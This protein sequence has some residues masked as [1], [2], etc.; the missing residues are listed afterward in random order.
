MRGL[1]R[2]LEPVAL[3]RIAVARWTEAAA[4]VAAA[5]ACLLFAE[6]ALDRHGAFESNAYDFGFF[7]QIIWNTSHGRWFQ[8]SFTPYNFVGQHFQ[9]VLLIFA[10]AY[11]L[12]AGVELLLVTQTV[13]VAAAALPLFYAVRRATASGVAGL[14][15]SAGFLLSASLHDALDFDFHPELMGF[16]FV[17]L[18][19]YYLVARRPVA[20]IVSL[21]PLLLL[22]EDMPLILAAFAVLMFARGFRREALA[23]FGVS[24]AFALG[25][26]LVLMPA[27][28]GG[29]G[30]LTQR[31]GYLFAD[32][33]WWSIVP[34][35]VSRAEHQL[36]GGPLAAV[37]R[38]ADSIGFTGL[39]NPIALLAAAPVFLLATLSDH[40]QQSQLE[41][42]Y[43]MAPLALAWVSAVFGVQRIASGMWPRWMRL[44]RNRSLATAAAGIIVLASSVT[45]F[46]LWSP[47]APGA[48]HHAPNA[49]HRAVVRDA[50]ALVPGDASVSAQNTLLPHLSERAKILE[51]PQVEDAAYVVVDPSLPVTGQA[52]AAGYAARIESLP[53]LGYE[54]IF[55]HDGV[56]VFRRTR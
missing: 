10:L 14:A 8:S 50:L 29:S 54:L 7:D 56:K 26:V 2:R 44:P 53:A 28:R 35:A 11:R 18:A 17:F 52:R 16:F 6:N 42:H 12:G 20:T 51:F 34:H 27:I 40:P 41:L 13:F 21:V 23:L 3:A 25:I 15:M 5:D 19:L 36:A 4:Y 33:T 46:V 47:Y 49:A 32:S 9:P 24:A 55:D 39:L 22:K 48:E 45:T 38:L 30:D 37:L 43:A 31:Y 1:W